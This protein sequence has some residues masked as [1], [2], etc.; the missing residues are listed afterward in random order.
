[1]PDMGAFLSLLQA[2]SRPATGVNPPPLMGDES[3]LDDDFDRV[4]VVVACLCLYC[5]SRLWRSAAFDDDR[6]SWIHLSFTTAR[7]PT[8]TYTGQREKV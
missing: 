5:N 3:L 2:P 6:F 4:L 1:M 8:A 7:E